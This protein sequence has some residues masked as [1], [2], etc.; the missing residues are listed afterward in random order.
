MLSS[1]QAP[2]ANVIAGCAV[3][4][5][6]AITTAERV[7]AIV[8]HAFVF[9]TMFILP[10]FPFRALVAAQAAFP[11]RAAAVGLRAIHACWPRPPRD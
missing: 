3:N 6:T 9:R 11:A 1:E 5:A 4:R 2:P 8:R 7:T 10:P